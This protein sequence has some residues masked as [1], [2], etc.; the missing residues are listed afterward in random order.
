[1]LSRI[2]ELQSLVHMHDGEMLIGAFQAREPQS[3]LA[4]REYAGLLPGVFANDPQPPRV[5]AE[6]KVRLAG[7]G[8]RQVAPSRNRRCAEGES[9]HGKSLQ[10]VR[11]D[12]R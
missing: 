1:M 10:M 6:Q 5:L 3:R 7:A 9:G 8:E 11:F 12:P 2:V 4:R